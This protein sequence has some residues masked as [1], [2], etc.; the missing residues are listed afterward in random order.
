MVTK[1]T[2]TNSMAALNQGKQL[3]ALE[4]ELTAIANKELRMHYNL[5]WIVDRPLRHITR[6]MQTA[7][8]LTAAR[9]QLKT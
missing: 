4:E 1:Q 5:R 3:I 6:A 9:Q 2:L 8:L 7:I